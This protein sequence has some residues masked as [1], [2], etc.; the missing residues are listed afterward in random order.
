M[1][2]M[3]ELP[4]TT[5]DEVRTPRPRAVRIRTAR[6]DGAFPCA[7]GE[8][9]KQQYDSALQ[10]WKKLCIPPVDPL[11]EGEIAALVASQL[12]EEALTKRNAAANR[13]YVHRATCSICRRRR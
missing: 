3:A 6:I 10:Q 13:M 7:D 2:L 1:I 5:L 9:L 8:D 11:E 12:K 4:E